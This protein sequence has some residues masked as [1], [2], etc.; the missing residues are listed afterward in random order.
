MV[1]V[2]VF[3]KIL[4]VQQK[5]YIIFALHSLQTYGYLFLWNEAQCAHNDID[6][7]GVTR[8]A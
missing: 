7:A 3:V 4:D 2:A 5:Y 1:L 6:T 8:I